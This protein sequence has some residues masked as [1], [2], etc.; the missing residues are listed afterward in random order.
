MTDERKK[1]FLLGAAALLAASV[2]IIDSAAHFDVSIA[3]LYLAVLLLIAKAGSIRDVAR[4]GLLCMGLAI[5]SWAIEHG[6]EPTAAN[7]LR[8]L[9]A[10]IA[11]GMT[12]VS[13]IGRKNLE[14]VRR[15]LERSRAEVEFFTDSVPQILWRATPQAHVD[16]YNKRYTE[17]IGRDFRETIEKQN[18]IEDIHP[19]DRAMF[20]DRVH[21][22]FEAGAELHA[23]Y[24]LRYADG[25][26][27]WMSISGRPVFSE[28][29][30]LLSYYGGTTDIHEDVLAQQEMQRLRAELEASKAELQSFTD[31]V[32]QILWRASPEGPV[33]YFNRR[34]TDLTGES[35]EDAVTKQAWRNQIHPGDREHAF[36]ALVESRSGKGPI[37]FKF[38]MRHADGS[39]RWMS[40]YALPV[41]AADGTLMGRYGGTV[42]IH[43]EVLAGEQVRLLN[44]TLEQRVA[45]RTAELMRTEARY[46]S[47]FDVSNMTFAEMDFSGA[48][49]ILDGLKAAGVE[50]LRAHMEANPETLARCLAAI[51]TT[52]VNEALARL[53]GY[54]DVAELVANPPAEN[55]EDG[56]E[57]QLRQ[58]EMAYY[59][60]DHI[61][62]R[63][64]LLG[65]EGL[66]VPVYFTVNRLGDG[67]HLS[68][69]LDLSEQERIESLHIAA[70]EELARA[71]RVATVGAF[72]ASI[73]HELNQPIASMVLDA[74]TGLRWLQ[75]E[76]PDTAS[77]ERSL[78]R[79]SRTAQRVASIVKRTRDNIVAGRRALTPVDLRELAAETRELLE[80]D[81]RRA[82]VTFEIRCDEDL[83][84]VLGDPVDIQQIFVNLATNAADAMRD[85]VG[86]KR[87]ELSIRRVPDGARIEV[88][89][90]G[91]GIP[92]HD[93]EK[94]FQPFFTTKPTGIGMGLQICRSAVE[95]LGGQLVAA[96]GPAGGALF[97]FT[98]PVMVEAPENR[99][100]LAPDDQVSG[101][102]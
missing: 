97:S 102:A 9:F 23:K 78:E 70:R 46:S 6:S 14:V 5:T 88:S 44:E 55:A 13:L 58:L 93:I 36:A 100:V 86:G 29:G 73:A 90:T 71:N 64:V 63:T 84:P 19:D 32:P 7:M 61:D 83:P 25:S 48:M 77:A 8:L 21:S 50:D 85:Q 15:E 43:E 81:M 75:R 41:F 60:I 52:R 12:A 39:Y 30:E 31:S 62:G 3:I 27:R 101:A 10:C 94:L 69:H 65:R 40:L 38:R 56:A 34:Y 42:D 51:R 54:K 26:Y 98:L 28:D 18:W 1:H 76:Q 96:N 49:P 4:G 37:R 20:L 89:D 74:Q 45:E 92:T 35:V 99:S 16:F 67:L 53:L 80:R 17:I 33:E 95:A 82:D 66:R 91:P 68:S 24:R 59:G 57:I 47:L 2:F 87:I 22:S 72:S 79:L 11:I